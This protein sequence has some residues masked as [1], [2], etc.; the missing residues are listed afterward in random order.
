MNQT[1]TCRR[2][3][4]STTVSRGKRTMK[5]CHWDLSN[6]AA[7]VTAFCSLVCGT[8]QLLTLQHRRRDLPPLV[9]DVEEKQQQLSP[10]ELIKEGR[11]LLRVRS[12]FVC[13]RKL[14][15]LARAFTTEELRGLGFDDF[16]TNRNQGSSY[17]N[18]NSYQTAG[19]RYRLSLSALT[20]AFQGASIVGLL[21]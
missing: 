10:S 18:V 5:Y 16:D 7:P 17:E 20:C 21:N 3:V 19:R 4:E 14:S 6:Q 9:S 11:L 1:E 12:T 15:G 8:R 13:C 2:F